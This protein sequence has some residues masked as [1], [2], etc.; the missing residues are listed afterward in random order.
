MLVLAAVQEIHDYEVVLSLPNG[1]T[2]FVAITDISAF[3]TQQLQ[4][5]NEG[6]KEDENVWN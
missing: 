2:A 1:L 4:V 6:G 3:F 5:M